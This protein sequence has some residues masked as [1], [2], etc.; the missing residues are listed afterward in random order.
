MPP[1]IGNLSSLIDLRLHDNQLSSIPPEIGDLTN[2]QDLDLFNNNLNNLPPEIGNLS[3]LRYLLLY[4]NQLDNLPSEVGNLSK[5]ERLIINDNLLNNLPPEIGSLTE[6]RWLVASNNKLSSLPSEI[7][8]LINLVN[9]IVDNNQLKVFPSLIND[10][11]NLG[12]LNISSNLLDSLPILYNHPRTPSLRIHTQNNYINLNDIAYN[13]TGPDSHSFKV[14]SYKPQSETIGKAK[15]KVVSTD[16]T[17]SLQVFYDNHSQTRFQWQK[18]QDGTWTD[19]AEQTKETYAITNTLLADAGQYRCQITNDWISNMT[20]YSA[21]ITLEVSEG[22]INSEEGEV[23]DAIEY[24][25][26]EALYNA[27]SGDSW[28]YNTNWL[29]GTTV[30]DISSWYN[31]VVEDNDV[32]KVI[33]PNNNLQGFIPSELGNLTALKELVLF[34]H[35]Q[36]PNAGQLSDVIPPE[37]G[38]LLNLEKLALGGSYHESGVGLTGTIPATLGQ[39]NKLEELTIQFTQISGEI[40]PELGQMGQLKSLIINHNQL[41]GTVPSQLSNLTQLQKLELSS[42]RLTG[43][44]DEIGDLS[45]LNT[46]NLSYNKIAGMLP[47]SF[48]Q[49]Q[50]LTHLVLHENEFTGQLPGSLAQLTNLQFMN[51][52]ENQF[53]GAI[54]EGLK[55]ISSFQ[56]FYLA[57]NQYTFQ[58][59]QPL[60][61]GTNQSFFTTIN[62]VSQGEVSLVASVSTTEG[63]SITIPYITGAS[64]NRYQ[65]QKQNGSSWQDIPEATQKDYFKEVVI[66]EDAGIYRCVV[67]NDWATQLTLITTPVTVGV[68]D[69]KNQ[70]YAIEDGLWMDAIW[71]HEPGGTP[72]DTY[73]QDDNEVFIVGHHVT[74]DQPLTTGPVHVIVNRAPASLTVDGAEMVIRGELDLTKQTEGFP[75]N[76]KVIN[77]GRIV[78][79]QP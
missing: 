34:E 30:A 70:Y 47:S 1:E 7:G 35:Y 33:L 13:L 3:N 69:A 68:K 60:F 39:L 27:T 59:I 46:L 25:A 61:T 32:T 37:L 9:L 17:I 41:S 44:A 63:L 5:L 55:A 56:T 6:L 71:A 50:N 65:W 42:N 58:N 77:N 75:G 53:S 11:A 78:P 40:P 62:Y 26:L 43:V 24:A 28:N 20:Q 67:S 12:T 29:Q 57:N 10:L 2:L 52:S 36:S 66:P 23:P 14:F 19:L 4:N 22:N 8:D 18:L 15:T 38:N 64:Q 51:I 74:L 31:V 72:V 45:Q 76:V 21:P 79:L 48:G 49:L 73:P 54:P 16:Q